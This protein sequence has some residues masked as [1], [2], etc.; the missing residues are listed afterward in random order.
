MTKK[1]LQGIRE[2]ARRANVAIATVDRV[3]HNRGGVSEQTR[4]KINKIINELNYQPNLLA[5][6]LASGK[7]I[8]LAVLIPGVTDETNFWE[9]PLKGIRRAEAEISQYGIS[10]EVFFFDLNHAHHFTQEAHRILQGGYDGLILSP[11]FV[12]EAQT[13]CE[14][15]RQIGLPFLFLDST[16]P[17][18]TNLSYVGPPLFESGYLAGKLS[19]FNKP[20]R[21]GRIHILNIAANPNSYTYREILTG[22]R[23]YLSTYSPQHQVTQLDIRQTDFDSIASRLQVFLETEP[24]PDAIFVSNSRVFSVARYL[25]T[26]PLPAKPL[27]IGFD[28]MEE[29]IRYVESGLIDFLICHQPESQGYRSIMLLYQYLVFSR[30][31]DAHYLMPIDIITKENAAFYHN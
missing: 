16:L 14:A 23:Q 22:F 2:I 9:A 1:K 28:Y 21:T 20:Q 18:E 12:E 4:E 30:T 5:S 10:I 27:L 8:R 19:T 29:N 3:I 31:P 11:S 26:R 24:W 13:L 17:N 25:S 6:R 15:C 7:I